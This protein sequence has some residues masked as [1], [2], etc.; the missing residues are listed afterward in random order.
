MEISF[1]NLH[2]IYTIVLLVHGIGHLIGVISIVGGLIKSPKFT[3]NSWLLSD[4]LGLSEAVVRALGML[5]L[6]AIV[7]F[8]AATWGFWFNLVWWRPLSWT[9]VALSIGLFVLWWNAF[10]VNLPIQ[11]NIGNII[12]IAGLFLL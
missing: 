5:W 11:A 8:I 6:V 4:R 1:L 12:V 2:L 9:M 3:S 10:T 7:G